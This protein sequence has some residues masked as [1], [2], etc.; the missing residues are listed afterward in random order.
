MRTRG[1]ILQLLDRS[2]IGQGDDGGI[3][4]MSAVIAL[5]FSVNNGTE[6]P[7]VS[8]EFRD[9]SRGGFHARQRART[10]KETQILS[11]GT[12]GVRGVY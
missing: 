8:K 11:R 1:A 9:W 6:I 3:N 12:G 7:L 10:I 5:P 4:G 2:V